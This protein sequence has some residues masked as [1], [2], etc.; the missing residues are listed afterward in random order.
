MC[1][2]RDNVRGVDHD[3][4]GSRIGGS[5]CQNHDNRGRLG[6]VAPRERL[7]LEPGLYHGIRTLTL[8]Q[9]C[10]KDGGAVDKGVRP[11]YSI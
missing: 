3:E 11:G 4:A 9:V 8:A 10:A 2:D 5:D 1:Q 6:A 7:T